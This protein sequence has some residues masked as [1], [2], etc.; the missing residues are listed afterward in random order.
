MLRH[1]FVTFLIVTVVYTG[2]LFVIGHPM[3]AVATQS[4]DEAPHQVTDV[5]LAETQTTQPD[6]T[7]NIDRPAPEQSNQPYFH[8]PTVV[9][10]SQVLDLENAE[11][12]VSSLWNAL[13]DNQDLVNQVKWQKGDIKAYAY[14]SDFNDSMTKARLTIGF[15]SK[16]LRSQKQTAKFT[17][18][19][20]HYQRYMLDFDTYSVSNEAWSKAHIN[21]N[22][23]ERHVL[24]KDGNR[25]SADA[26]VVFN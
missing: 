19:K 1:F 22:L 16:D 12:E 26:I 8:G 9:G 2:L 13:L 5:V 17:L 6:S 21:G 4:S 14:Y 24:N 11:L 15:D 25:V 10:I 18:P 20:G 7:K 23:I 3:V